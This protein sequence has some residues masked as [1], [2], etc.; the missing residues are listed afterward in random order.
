MT[1]KSNVKTL[2]QNSENQ[3]LPQ[4]QSSVQFRHGYSNRLRVQV[5]FDGPGKT[6]QEFKDE[7]DINKIMA[8]YQQTGLLSNVTTK[9]PQFA[10]VDGQTFYDAMLVVAESKT[11][12]EQLPS[13]VRTKFE[14]DPGK[15]LDFVHD[16]K[17]LPEMAEMGLTRP[18]A[19][20]TAPPTLEPTTIAPEPLKTNPQA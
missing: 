18:A 5:V 4:S 17:N 9:L 19:V 12:F 1:T 14:N 8:R 11:L 20:I 10:D 6:K 16:P 3:S 13:L 15:F 7:S 2:L